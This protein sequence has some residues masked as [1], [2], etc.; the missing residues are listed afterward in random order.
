MDNYR[1]N[2]PGCKLRKESKRLNDENES[3]RQKVAETEFQTAMLQKKIAAKT[4]V[5]ATNVTTAAETAAATAITADTR[6][7]RGAA[8]A[9]RNA[10]EH[11]CYQKKK[12]MPKGLLCNSKR[13]QR[14]WQRL[15]S[16]RE[17]PSLLLLDIE[18]FVAE[19]EI[20]AAAGGTMQKPSLQRMR[21][22]KM[23]KVQVPISKGL[24]M[25][26]QRQGLFTGEEQ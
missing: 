6:A 3:L 12:A 1:G 19:E 21:G 25:L 23:A 20:A 15:D 18:V 26:E 24:E 17:A 7:R 2:L 4:T 5:A 22:G 10:L 16:R 9:A 14:Q 13:S 8:T 11:R